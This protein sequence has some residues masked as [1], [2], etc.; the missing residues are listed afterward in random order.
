MVGGDSDAH[1][2]RCS[3]DGPIALS[4]QFAHNIM[5]RDYCKNK[6]AHFSRPMMWPLAGIIIALLSRLA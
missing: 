5:I 6:Q 3:G 4:L 2:N 1:S